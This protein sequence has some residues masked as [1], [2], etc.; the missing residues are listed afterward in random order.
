MA[1]VCALLRRPEVRLLTL[2][3]PGGVG[4]TR[5]ALAVAAALGEAFADGVAWVEL[6]PLRDPTLVATAVA[7]ALGI[8]EGGG[9]AMAELLTAGAGG[10]PTP[11]DPRQL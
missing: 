1:A 10:T 7:A 9:R 5:L 6:A 3:G 4:K 8:R 11:A 2:S